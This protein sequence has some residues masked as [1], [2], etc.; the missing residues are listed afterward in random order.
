MSRRT[1]LAS[2]QGLSQAVTVAVT[3]CFCD[4]NRACHR[5][6]LWLSQAVTVAVTGTVTGCY[7]GCHRLLLW[8]LQGLSQAVTV[9]VTGWYCGCH[10]DCHRLLLWLSQAVTVTV[11]GPIFCTHRGKETLASSRPTWT[12]RGGKGSQM[13][14]RDEEQRALHAKNRAAPV[15]LMNNRPRSTRQTGKRTLKRGGRMRSGSVDRAK[16]VVVGA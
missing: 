1:S 14:N 5:L 11:T 13:L 15:R 4:C 7:C 6:L 8:L 10:R 3:G 2:T 16:P 12:A 9:A